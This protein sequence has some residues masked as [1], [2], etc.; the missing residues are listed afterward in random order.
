M[1]DLLKIMGQV[2]LTVMVGMLMVLPTAS[3]VYLAIVYESWL[4][5]ALAFAVFILTFSIGIYL[6]EA[7]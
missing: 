2:T 4:L 3:A 1:N 5:G 7:E 6:M